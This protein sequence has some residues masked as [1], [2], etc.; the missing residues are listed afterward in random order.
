MQGSVVLQLN[1]E[2]S[3][4]PIYAELL[5]LNSQART[6]WGIERARRAHHRLMP[7]LLGGGA[8]SL[9]LG[10]PD[11]AASLMQFDP[12]N[13]WQLSASVAYRGANNLYRSW[14]V[15]LRHGAVLDRLCHCRTLVISEEAICFGIK[16]ELLNVKSLHGDY[17][18]DALLEIVAGFWKHQQTDAF[19]LFS[20]Q[21]LFIQRDLE[22]RAIEELQAAGAFG[23]RGHLNGKQIWVGGGEM[24]KNLG[25]QRP[26]E[27]LQR[28]GQ[29]GR[30]HV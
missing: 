19:P 23:L 16:R 12:I 10:Y 21:P 29:I 15:R 9:L 8:V 17:S 27:M 5:Q 24:L 14:G 25:I 26:P 1:Q 28:R 11:Q 3:E 6:P 2:L 18:A 20:L 13:D 22:P 30:A 4:Q 7:L